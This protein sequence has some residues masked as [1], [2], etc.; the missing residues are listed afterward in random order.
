[1]L[2]SRNRFT[3]ERKLTTAVDYDFG[4]YG[5]ASLGSIDSVYGYSDI[6]DFVGRADVKP[7]SHVQWSVI[8]NPTLYHPFT[9]EGQPVSFSK[10]FPL[11]LGEGAFDHVFDLPDESSLQPHIL[12]AFNAFSI[13]FP[14]KFAPIEFVEGLKEWRSL[15]PSF[16]GDL[17]K[18]V[19]SLHLTNQFGWQ[20]VIADVT[21]LSSLLVKC[22]DRLD[23]LRRTYGK[24]TPLYFAKRLPSPDM[25]PWRYTFRPGS[26]GLR[27][28][29]IDVEV[30]FVAKA[31]LLHRIPHLDDST[32]L[33][34][35]IVSA[36]GFNNPLKAIWQS[37][38]LSFLVDW[39]VDVSGLL[40][41]LAQIK[42][43]A[44]WSLYNT[45]HSVSLDARFSIEQDNHYSGTT[46]E[47]VYLNDVRLRRYRRSLGLP[48]KLTD[49]V[50]GSLNPQQQGLLAALFLSK[51]HR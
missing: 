17:V 7:C 10:Q 43:A 13:V 37:L 35:A 50:S 18:D 24:P 48:L 30:K 51:G 41:R 5:S 19:S 49:M 32:G 15:L 26:W 1:M 6:S 29:P 16:S 27:I 47:N 12:D 38:R 39:I 23:W 4:V 20:N 33:Y 42:P 45:T 14:S 21:Y 2:R 28:I 22:R 3:V 46:S 9:T 36:L 34:Q 31:T 8:G 40:D 44:E 11:P 25:S